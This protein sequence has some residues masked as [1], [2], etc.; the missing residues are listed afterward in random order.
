MDECFSYDKE[1]LQN[2]CMVGG[3]ALQDAR[4]AASL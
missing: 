3:E 1:L 2:G 4:N